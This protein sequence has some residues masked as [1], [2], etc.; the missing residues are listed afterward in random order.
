MGARS[1]TGSIASYQQRFSEPSGDGARQ[2]GSRVRGASAGRGELASV[3]DRGP[4]GARLVDDARD[5]PDRVGQ[6]AGDARTIVVLVLRD[7]AESSGPDPEPRRD[8][9]REAEHL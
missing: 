9:S 1:S 5:V 4:S 3:P 8:R 7:G 2:G 6:S